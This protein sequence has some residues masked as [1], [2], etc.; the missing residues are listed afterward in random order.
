MAAAACEIVEH[1]ESTLFLGWM[2]REAPLRFPELFAQARD[3]A[4]RRAIATSLGLALWNATPL[5][6]NGYQPE[7]LASPS[8]EQPCPCES[9]EPYCRCCGRFA[10]FPGLEV[11]QMWLYVVE[12]L[13]DEELWE[14]G[15]SGVMELPELA[16]AAANLLDRGQP[17]RCLRLL[18][19]LFSTPKQ[20]GPQ[21]EMLLDPMLEAFRMVEPGMRAMAMERL[22]ATLPACLAAPLALR[23]A[24]LLAD[25]GDWHSAWAC[26]ADAQKLDP[27]QQLLPIAEVVLLLTEDRTAQAA[28][29]SRFWLAR[30]RRNEELTDSPVGTF[31]QQVAS[32]PEATRAAYVQS[33]EPESCQ[34]FLAVMLRLRES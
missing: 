29:R 33:G 32:D 12:R 13:S 5:P 19:P 24:A 1:Q 34:D 2:Q 14:V 30:S 4:A 3:G 9:D 11:E 16:G 18:A 21:H 6:R 15:R 28:L 22:I 20:L 25:A 17:R 7:P 8:P 31:L 10:A 26:F 27:H 23:R